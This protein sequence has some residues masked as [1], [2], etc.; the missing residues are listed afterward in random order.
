MKKLG[1]VLVVLIIGSYANAQSFYAARKE[2]SLLL[3]VGTGSSTY[4]GEMADD[5]H[6]FDARA[7]F[8]LGAQYYLNNKFSLRSEVTWFTLKGADAKSKQPEDGR[9][10]RNLSFSSNNY[11]I[12]VSGVVSLLPQGRR[13]YQRPSFNLYAFGGIGLLYYNPTAEYQ[14]QKHALRP[15]ETEHVHYSSFTM[16][17]P[18]GA[19]A[20]FKISPLANISIEGGFR[21]TFTDYLDDVSTVHY[22]Q[23]SFTDPIAAALS[24]RRPEIGL[25]VAAPGTVRGNPQ[26]KD[27]YFLLTAKLE[28]YLPAQFGGPNNSKKLYR[29]K[30]KAFYRYNKRGGM[31]K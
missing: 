26:Y 1:L 15:L 7:T 16:V 14:G 25:P 17:I 11:E 30:R 23:S 13:F 12:N 29:S 4:F 22:A 6:Y 20:R 18:F 19:G 3:I 21:K 28:Y 8:N 31:R 5:G 10:N 27:A 9:V 24:D 2:R